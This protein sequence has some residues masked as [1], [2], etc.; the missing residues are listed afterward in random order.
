M[1]LHNI[2]GAEAEEAVV[3]YLQKSGYKIID[4]NWKTKWCEIDII[5][6]K[7]K[8]AHFVEVKYRS[9]SSQGSGFDYITSK[10]LTQ[11]SRAA[12]SWVTINKWDGEYV[13]SAAEVSGHDYKID[14]IEEI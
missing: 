2:H 7:N 4:H 3:K 14:F 11:M 12:D 1:A 8:V 10:K 13:L 6:E 5:A 9:N